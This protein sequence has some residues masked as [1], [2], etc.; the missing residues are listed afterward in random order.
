[1]GEGR[2]GFPERTVCLIRAAGPDL[3]RLVELSDDIA[4]FRSAKEVATFFIEQENRDQAQ[5][6]TDLLNRVEVRDRDQICV[7]VLDHGI[8]NGHRLLEPVLADEDRHTVEPAW[9]VNDDHGHGTLM[10]GL[11]A[12]GDIL[13]ALQSQS[14][15]VISHGLESAKILPPPPETNPKRLWGHFTAQGISRAEVQAPNRKRITCMAITSVDD[16][17]RGRPFFLVRKGGRAGLGL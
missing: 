2:I 8:N 9:G 13:S 4:E 11:A 14:A 10:A 16:R 7:L 15:L 6:V 1:M 3:T 17:D 5:W 12:Y